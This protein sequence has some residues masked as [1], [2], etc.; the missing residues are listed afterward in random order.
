[1]ITAAADTPLQTWAAARTDPFMDDRELEDVLADAPE[2]ALPAFTRSLATRPRVDA[3]L[4]RWVL[5]A[6]WLPS[7]AEQ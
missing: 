3:Q 6:R 5:L 7:P 1:M 2:A 4:A